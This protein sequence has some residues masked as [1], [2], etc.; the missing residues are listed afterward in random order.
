L[1]RLIQVLRIKGCHR[2]YYTRETKICGKTNTTKKTDILIAD[3]KYGFI[4]RVHKRN[5]QRKPAKTDAKTGMVI[6]FYSIGCLGI[7]IFPVILGMVPTNIHGWGLSHWTLGFGRRVKF[8][9]CGVY[10]KLGCWR[11]CP[12]GPHN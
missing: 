4:G 9:K 2:T 11:E 12:K 3:A 8:S 5:F 6:L 1:E 7:P 10:Q